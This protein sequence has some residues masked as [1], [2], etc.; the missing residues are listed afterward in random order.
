MSEIYGRR[1]VYIVSNGL[2]TLFN[3]AG[4]LSPNIG[5]LIAFRFL[6]GL[7]ASTPVTIGGGSVADMF[8]PHERG[9]AMSFYIGGVL[10]GPS[11]GLFLIISRDL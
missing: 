10:I 6:G 1:P 2:W 5:A 11:I 9:I 7:C 4:A 3:I 8:R